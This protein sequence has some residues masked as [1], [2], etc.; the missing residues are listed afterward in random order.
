MHELIGED[1]EQDNQFWSQ[2][3]FQDLEN[4]DEY[5]TESDK[6]DKFDEDFFDSE[7]EDSEPPEEKPR[8]V[9]KQRASKKRPPPK[10]AKS[11]K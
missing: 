1:K 11:K 2:N 7:S 9:T 6:G 5:T 8:R 10:K 3:F 4:D